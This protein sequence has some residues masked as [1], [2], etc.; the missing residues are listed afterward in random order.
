MGDI[1]EIEPQHFVNL[2]NYASYFYESLKRYQEANSPA[3]EKDAEMW[4]YNSIG[5]I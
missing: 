4:L 1:C 2:Q 5:Y 3:A